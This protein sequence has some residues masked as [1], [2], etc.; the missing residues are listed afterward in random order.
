MLIKQLMSRAALGV[1]P[2]LILD[3]LKAGSAKT[4]PFGLLRGI[5]VSGLKH[6]GGI[7][8]ALQPAPTP[9]PP[10]VQVAPTPGPVQ[11]AVAQVIAERAQLVPDVPPPVVQRQPLP[12][13]PPPVVQ[14]QPLPDVPPPVVRPAPLPG[15]VAQVI[16]E[17]AQPVPAQPT[18]RGIDAINAAVGVAKDKILS[19][20]T[21][22]LTD[23][24]QSAGAKSAAL[25]KAQADSGVIDGM[26]NGLGKVYNKFGQT[27]Q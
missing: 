26:I 21:G 23:T 8:R 22:L 24:T 9:A 17:R 10:P 15:W 19:D 11:G 16:A 6:P 12:D 1:A 20:L 14:Q 4:G 27:G 3:D 13:V 5:A 7:A 25:L 2:N 18:G